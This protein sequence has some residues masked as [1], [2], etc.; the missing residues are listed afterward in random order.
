MSNLN[1]FAVLDDILADYASPRVRRLVHSL[2]F[3]I[4]AV[5][6]IWM[7]AQ[8]DWKKF[9]IA[10]GAALYADT[11]RVNTT[12]TDEFTDDDSVT[13]YDAPR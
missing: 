5:V 6:A 9:F 10:L 11:N 4:A 2:L 7:A 1:P 12:P 13:F 8:G 3:L